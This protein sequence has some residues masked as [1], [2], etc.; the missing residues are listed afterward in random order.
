MNLQ[1]KNSKFKILQVSDPQDMHY[2]RRSMLRM[3]DRAYD[4]IKPDLVVFTGD[5]VLSN[6]LLDARFGNKQTAEGYETTKERMKKSLEI[7][8]EPLEK[9]NI[10]F[11]MI[12]GNH[13]DM[14]CMTKEEI[15]DL[16]REYS[17]FVGLVDTYGHGDI[18]THNILIY[19]GDTPKF[20]LWM[21]DTSR[22]NKDEDRGYEGVTTEAVEWYKQT[23]D[24]LGKLPSLMFQHIPM[25]ETANCIEECNKDDEGAVKD[26]DGDR[27]IRLKP[28]CINSGRLWEPSPGCKANYGQYDAVKA[29][30][31]V[32]AVVYGHHHMNLF[33][34]DCDG[35]RMIQ[36]PA[37]SFRCYGNENKGVR[38]FEID[39]NNPNEFSTRHITYFDLMGKTPLSMLGYFIDADELEKPRRIALAALGATAAAAVTAGIV[40]AIRK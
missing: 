34:I 13:D 24:A 40:K 22:Q 29:Q 28:E 8:L 33:D 15:I 20:N 35:V 1:F 14:C 6:H 26:Y 27:Y 3:L 11:G 36:T 19:S 17:C 31:D 32:L 25:T 2:P 37:A 16:Y 21:M 39:E 30:G 9:R 5:N 4:T 18:G 23:S 12:F 7:I 38:L 10:P